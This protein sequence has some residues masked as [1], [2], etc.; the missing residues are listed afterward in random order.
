MLENEIVLDV[1]QTEDI[2]AT[3]EAILDDVETEDMQSVE[4]QNEAIRALGRAMDRPDD[5]EAK[6]TKVHG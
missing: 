2:L 1:V 3:K 5:S 4:M 6:R